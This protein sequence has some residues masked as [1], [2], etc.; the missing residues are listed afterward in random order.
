MSD[1][2]AVQRMELRR[3]L[4]DFEIMVRREAR[5]EGFDAGVKWAVEWLCKRSDSARFARG[6]VKH[7]WY[8]NVA[9]DMERAAAERG[10]VSQNKGASG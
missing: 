5:A 10:D 1:S 4:T 2:R 6:S 3:L 8:L 9:T 7:S